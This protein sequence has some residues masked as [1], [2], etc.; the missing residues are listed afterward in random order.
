[1]AMLDFG[2]PISLFILGIIFYQNYLKKLC[3]L[4]R[5]AV[6]RYF[7]NKILHISTI[8]GIL[9]NFIVLPA[10]IFDFGSH[11]ESFYSHNGTLY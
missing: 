10:A 8:F 4:C 5:L 9:H 7:L 3:I 6:K 1:M 2:S 11:F